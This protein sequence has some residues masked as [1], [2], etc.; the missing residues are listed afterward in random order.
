MLFIQLPIVLFTGTTLHGYLTNL[1][2]IKR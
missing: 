1:E 2:T